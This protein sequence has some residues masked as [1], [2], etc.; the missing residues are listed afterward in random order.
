MATNTSQKRR[1]F[2][3]L[4][5]PSLEG[6]PGWAI[7]SVSEFMREE[8]AVAISRTTMITGSVEW[9]VSEEKDGTVM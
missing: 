5:G 7:S 4:A 2:D 3:A 6:F 9:K 1:P 8:E